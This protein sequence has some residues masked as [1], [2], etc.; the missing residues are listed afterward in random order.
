MLGKIK[1]LYDPEPARMCRNI[2][3]WFWYN[4]EVYMISENVNEVHIISWF[5]FRKLESQ[6]KNFL[7]TLR[8]YNAYKE[9][10]EIVSTQL[11]NNTVISIVLVINHGY[12]IIRKTTID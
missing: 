6:I 4:S 10:S 7:S 3:P 8:L 9:F 5:F 2:L 1:Y 12:T 11:C